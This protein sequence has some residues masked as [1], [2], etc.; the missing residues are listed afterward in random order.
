MFLNR[1]IFKGDMFNVRDRDLW[2][3][4]NV[5]PENIFLDVILRSPTISGTT[6]NL[7]VSADAEVLRGVYPE[8]TEGLRMTLGSLQM[9]TEQE[10]EV[11]D[12]AR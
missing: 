6:K 1:I 9:D 10:V 7:I 5:N 11:Y 2:R 12:K 4:T 8:S 3:L